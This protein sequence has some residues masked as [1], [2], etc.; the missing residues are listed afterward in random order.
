MT[1]VRVAWSRYHGYIARRPHLKRLCQTSL[2]FMHDHVWY[3]FHRSRTF[4]GHT[5]VFRVLAVVGSNHVVAAVGQPCL[6]PTAPKV[7]QPDRTTPLAIIGTRIRSAAW[8]Q[9]AQHSNTY[10]IKAGFISL[11]FEKHQAKI[12]FLYT[13]WWVLV[14]D[15]HGNDHHY[16][17]YKPVKK[18]TWF[19]LATCRHTSR[20][21]YMNIGW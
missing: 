15:N 12:F 14:C 1:H 17:R 4:A 3:G 21:Y 7:V 2:Q 19:P 6:S 11:L 9:N 13:S 10:L 18:F 20:M 5:G 16:C 8:E